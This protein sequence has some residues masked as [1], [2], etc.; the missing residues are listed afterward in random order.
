MFGVDPDGRRA[1]E[2]ITGLARAKQFKTLTILPI[3]EL[4]GTAEG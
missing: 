1:R 2:A 3:A 4:I